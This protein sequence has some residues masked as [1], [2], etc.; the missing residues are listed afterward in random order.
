[1]TAAFRLFVF[2]AATLFFALP[3]TSQQTAPEGDMVLVADRVYVTP[4]NILIAEGQ[5]EALQGDVR[6]RAKKIE[7]DGSSDIIKVTGPI[8]FQQSDYVRIVASY[9]ELD[10][11]FRTAVLKSARLVMNEHVQMASVELHRVE[12]RYNVLHKTS[13]SSCQVCDNGKPPL[14]QI[15]ARRVVHDQEER[16]VY[17]DH[18]QLRVLDVPVFYFP[19]LRMPDPTLK[20]ANGF[21]IPELRQNSQLGFGIKIPYFL[22]LGDHK[23]LLLTPYLSEHSTT[24]EFRYRQAFRNGRMQWEGAVSD[25]SFYPS[26]PRYYL[27]ADGAFDLKRDYKLTFNVQTVSDRAY[28]QDYNYSDEDRLTSD[29]ALRRSRRDENTRIALYHYK[30]LRASDDNDTL[31]SWVGIAETER[32]YFPKIIGGEAR[33]TLQLRGQYRTSD[34]DTDGGD[35]D[36]DTDGR[37]AVGATAAMWWRRNWTLNNGLRTG[38]TGELAADTY[39]TD[40]DAVYQGTESQITP[41]VAAHFRY[42]MSKLG[43][44]G[45]TYVIEPLAQISYSGGDTLNIAND[46]SSRVEFDEGNLLALSRFPSTDRRE[47]GA[48]GAVGMNWARYDPNGWQAHLSFGQVYHQSPHPDFSLTSGLSGTTSDF[49]M[50]GQITTQNGLQLMA[51]GLWDGT[52]GFNKASARAGWTN[53]KLWLDASYIWLRADAQE[54]RTQNLSEWVLDTRY[55]MSRHWTASADWRF[56]AAAGESAEAGIGFEYRNECVK[57]GLSVSRNFVNSAT[58]RPST[59]IGLTVALL[60]FSVNAKDKSY[61][62]TCSANAG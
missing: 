1:M 23:D 36:T 28:L 15:R 7:Y 32:R 62:R 38:I 24:L 45:S 35:I 54:D 10:K 37:D 61:N 2:V 21:L 30:S 49:L 20:R 58:V 31:P 13:V 26:Q 60:G 34:L 52:T 22:T 46:E 5:V 25:D 17:F 40:Q 59:D 4:D 43:A 14:W 53:K 41:T 39:Y 57:I 11:D 27:F 55:R 42:P 48:V 8:H 12:G 6:L 18:A 16:Q 9:A 33:M 50:A 29:I 3:A 56:D 47:R 44:D 51:R 19:Q